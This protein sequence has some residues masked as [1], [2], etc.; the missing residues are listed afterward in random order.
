[1]EF[2][3]QAKLGSLANDVY[4]ITII[5]GGINGAGIALDA[6]LRGLKVLL[7]EKDDFGNNKIENLDI[8]AGEQTERTVDISG[9][10]IVNHKN[11]GSIIDS[12]YYQFEATTFETDTFVVISATD[13]ISVLATMD[14]IF[15]ESF[16]GSLENLKV[17]ID[18]IEIGRAHV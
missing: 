10:N 14:S 4:D 11:P 3:K 12:I 8:V 18:P 1:M 6:A 13:E 15:I 17:D 2:V 9:F 5:G 16:T 7:L